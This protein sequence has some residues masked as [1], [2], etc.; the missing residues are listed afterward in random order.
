M[1]TIGQFIQSTPSQPHGLSSRDIDPQNDVLSALRSTDR[2]IVDLFKHLDAGD[3]YSAI[4]TG[5]GML[6]ADPELYARQLARMGSALGTSGLALFAAEQLGLFVLNRHGKIWNPATLA[7]PPIAQNFIP[8]ALDV[9]TGTPQVL[10]GFDDSLGTSDITARPGFFEVNHGPGADDR[11][12]AL[13]QGNYDEFRVVHYPPFVQAAIGVGSTGPQ[14][15]ARDFGGRLVGAR[16]QDTSLVDDLVKGSDGIPKPIVQA[17]LE[18]RNKYFPGQDSLADGA[19]FPEHAV[20]PISMLVDDALDGTNKSGHMVPVAGVTR[21]VYRS[22]KGAAPGADGPQPTAGLVSSAAA[23]SAD[24][25]Q[26]PTGEWRP[27]TGEAQRASSI[28]TSKLEVSA[29]PGGII[30]VR[31][32]ADNANG[33]IVTTAGQ[34]PTDVIDDDTAYMPLSFTDLRPADG[35][36]RTVYFR[37]FITDLHESFAPEWNKQ[38][39]FGRTDPVATYT[40]TNRSVT[41]GFKLV[42]FSP[43][44]VEVIYQKLGWLTSMVYPEYDQELLYLSGPVVRLRVGDVIN[45][46]GPE[47]ARGLPGII[48]SLEF[49]YSESPWELRPGL[50]VPRH[51]SV[52]LSF[53]VLHDRPIGRGA[54]GKFGGLGTIKDGKFIP[55][56]RSNPPS[57]GSNDSTPFP[58][59]INGMDSFR[60]LGVSDT[61]SMNDYDQLRNSGD[62]ARH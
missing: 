29:F 46:L 39:F 8:A 40:S 12:L 32:A 37:P 21:Y 38:G 56:S 45:A 26:L 25:I 51:V 55:P 48:E 35:S 24:R 10:T 22:S 34:S 23:F 3:R 7:P 28:G 53:L 49:D 5:P 13:A 44:D 36:F 18:L 47:G 52:S 54:A 1:A 59:V 58:E 42:A 4:A 57:A 30:P 61:D 16:S 6:A 62:P 20:A 43:E 14:N 33:F 50:K 27:E 11:Q 17:A 60:S 2:A 31:F 9:L 19:V 15:I 41:L